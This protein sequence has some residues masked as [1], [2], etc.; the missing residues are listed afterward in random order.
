KII[1]QPDALLGT[2]RLGN[3]GQGGV[4][5]R[6]IGECGADLSN[7]TCTYPAGLVGASV[8]R[9]SS[10]C[11]PEYPG[12]NAW[13]KIKAI[14]SRSSVRRGA[15]KLEAAPIRPS[16]RW[17]ANPSQLASSAA[18]MIKTAQDRKESANQLTSL[19]EQP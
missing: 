13:S 8:S 17:N 7:C 11:G 2:K 19:R 18:V 14:T 15:Q 16:G 1:P 9:E 12:W 6:P 3:P 10:V 4:Y 5:Q